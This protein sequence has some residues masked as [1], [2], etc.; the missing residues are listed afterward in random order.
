MDKSPADATLVYTQHSVAFPSPSNFLDD[1]DDE[2]GVSLEAPDGGTYGEMYWQFKTF[3]RH[4]HGVQMRVFGDGLSC[5][6]DPR[7]QRVVKKWWAN[8]SPD[9]ISPTELIAWLE[10]EGVVPSQYQLR[11]QK[12]SKSGE[13]KR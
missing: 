13:V 12:E 8:K 11:G 6:A 2:V 5:L 1:C 4:Q 10:A 3:T 9:E 7:I